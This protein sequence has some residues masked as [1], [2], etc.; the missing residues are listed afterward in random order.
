[1]TIHL[2]VSSLQPIKKDHN[3]LLAPKLGREL[4]GWV[5]DLHLQV[6]SLTASVNLIALTSNAPCMAH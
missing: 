3:Q 5:Q 6:T 1:M 4:A 2:C